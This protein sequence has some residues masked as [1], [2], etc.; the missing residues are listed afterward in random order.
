[1]KNRSEH[2]I[3]NVRYDQRAHLNKSII[4]LYCIHLYST[5]IAPNLGALR[6]ADT[7]K[8]TL[9]IID[10]GRLALIYTYETPIVII[11]IFKIW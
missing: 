4:Y 3:K 5:Y 2:S 8:F 1:M 6:I 10:G 9:E 11:E 7:L